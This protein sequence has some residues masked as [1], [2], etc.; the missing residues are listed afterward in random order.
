[1]APEQG[2]G[3]YYNLFKFKTMGNARSKT[4]G[5]CG[6]LAEFY[7]KELCKYQDNV[8]NLD[9]AKS[10]NLSERLY[11]DLPKCEIMDQRWNYSSNNSP[12]ALNKCACHL[13][14]QEIPIRQNFYKRL[15]PPLSC[16]G[17]RTLMKKCTGLRMRPRT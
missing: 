8:D 14:E 15:P 3:Q 4:M 2:R 16:S 17:T 10:V 13:I 11:S 12:R 9:K 6:N 5:K 1:M 7:I